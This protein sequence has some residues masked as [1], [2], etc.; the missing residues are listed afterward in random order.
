M[1]ALKFRDDHTQREKEKRDTQR[2]G[3]SPFEIYKG[4]Y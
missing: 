2:S 4:D 1:M 3:S